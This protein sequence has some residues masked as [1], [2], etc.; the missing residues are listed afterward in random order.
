MDKVQ[1]IIQDTVTIP[2]GKPD[3]ARG[4]EAKA[5]FLWMKCV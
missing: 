1:A 5:K 3:A 2:D 4:V